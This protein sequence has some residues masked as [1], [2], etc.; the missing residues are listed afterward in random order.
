MKSLPN[1]S[2][3]EERK[4]KIQEQEGVFLTPS[5][6]VEFLYC[7]RFTYFMN[8]LNILQH[9][10]Q[11]YKVLLGRELHDKKKMIN[12]DYLRKKIECVKKDLDVYMVSRR[13]HLKGVVDEVLYLKDGSLSPFDYKFAEYTEFVYRTHRVQSILYGLM[14]KDYYKAEVKRG[15]ICYSRSNYKVKEVVFKEN[16][17]DEGKK[18]IDEML[19][20]IQL[21]YYPKMTSYRVRCVDCCYRNICV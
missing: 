4:D 2:E 20:I 17:F 6:I 8:C 11:R 9:E 10:E 14:I 16:D 13:Y 15:F 7:P 19:H 12:R 18:I 3:R 5:E 1:L 21:G